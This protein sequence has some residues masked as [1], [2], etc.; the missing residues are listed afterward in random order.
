MKVSPPTAEYIQ[1]H[2]AI[3][4]VHHEAQCTRHEALPALVA[5]LS[6]AQIRAQRRRR[7]HDQSYLQFDASEVPSK[8]WSQYPFPQSWPVSPDGFSDDYYVKYDDLRTWL[9]S[10]LSPQSK[11]GEK[12]GPKPRY[13]WERFWIE[14]VRIADLHGLPEKQGDLESKMSEWFIADIDDSPAVSTIREK[15]GKL[16]KFKGR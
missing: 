3:E 13:D 9:D 6:N 12:R 10:S 4:I 16:Y 8:F 15:V 7:G 1:F 14:V 11:L 5:A 2:Q